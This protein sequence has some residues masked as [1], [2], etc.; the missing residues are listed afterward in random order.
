MSETLQY[1]Q[2]YDDTKRLF[3]Q[4]LGNGVVM[5]EYEDDLQ[6]LG[7]TIS[8]RVTKLNMLMFHEKA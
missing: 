1:D 4:H 3:R 7:F 6:R 8:K 2:G 5:A